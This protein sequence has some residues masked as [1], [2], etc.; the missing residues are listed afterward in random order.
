MI[1]IHRGTI[2]PNF[3]QDLTRLET[4]G[5]HQAIEILDDAG[6]LPDLDP[7]QFAYSSSGEYAT[8]KHTG[9]PYHIEDSDA[10]RYETLLFFA[11][12]YGN[13]LHFAT[14]DGEGNRTYYRV[15]G[16]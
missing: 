14:R 11:V 2:R 3:K 13:T 1:D 5:I 4:L 10:G 6:I 8:Y 12:T 7:S 9:D 16:F 15:T